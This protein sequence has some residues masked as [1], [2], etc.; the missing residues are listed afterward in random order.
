MYRDKSKY[1]IIQVPPKLIMQAMI[2]N[3]PRIAAIF[4]ICDSGVDSSSSSGEGSSSS[5]GDGGNGSSGT[6]TNS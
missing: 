1:A 6:I 2:K 5:G 3:I 4:E